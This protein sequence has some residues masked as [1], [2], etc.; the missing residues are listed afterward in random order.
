MVVRD[1]KG[2]VFAMP[3]SYMAALD[4]NAAKQIYGVV[5]QAVADANRDIIAGLAALIVQ[6]FQPRAASAPSDD[7]N[8]DRLCAATLTTGMC[9]QRRAEH[10]IE[11]HEY[12]A[13]GLE[14]D[15]EGIQ[16]LDIAPPPEEE[17][18][19]SESES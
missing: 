17:A 4:E 2:N 11:G 13:G 8:P 14:Q 10:P 6:A 7:D 1:A 16:T 19:P 9:N 12:V 15:S 5:R 3:F 18:P